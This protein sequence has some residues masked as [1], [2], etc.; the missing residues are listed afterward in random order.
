MSAT[1]DSGAPRHDPQQTPVPTPHLSRGRRL[2]PERYVIGW[3]DGIIKVGSTWFGRTRWG[4]FTSTGGTLVARNYYPHLG[5]SIE[6]ERWL[7]DEL[8]KD[9]PLAFRD[10]ADAH[11]Y[12]GGSGWLECYRVPVCDW[13]KI[14]KLAAGEVTSGMVQR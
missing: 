8:A 14:E 3:P 12:L 10:A 2:I 1:Q 4:R 9:Y 7:Q 5:D 13:P 11:P 6:A